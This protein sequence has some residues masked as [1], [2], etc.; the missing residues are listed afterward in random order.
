MYYL[1][2]S[3]DADEFKAVRGRLRSDLFGEA[4]NRQTFSKAADY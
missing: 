2:L 3:A 1:N 4:T